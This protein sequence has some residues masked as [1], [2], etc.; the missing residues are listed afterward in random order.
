MRQSTLT[1]CGLLLAVVLNAQPASWEAFRS[2]GLELQRRAMLVLGTWAVGNLALGTTL[3]LRQDGTARYFH[4][5]NAGWNLVNL[6]LATAGYLQAVRGGVVAV[7][8]PT[9]VSDHYG[10]QKTLL[11]NVGLDTGYMLGGW[12]LMERSRRVL[13]KPERLKG[14]GQSLVMQGGFLFVFDLVFH[15]V[16][17]HRNETLSA[18]LE[19]LS[20]Q[21]GAVHFHYTFGG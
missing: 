11:L 4:Q 15:Q 6:G 8:L 17:A 5:M 21:G 14:F 12:Y 2:D 10:L 7:D 9:L 3:S 13:H 19:G 1:F 18:F 20:W 16:L